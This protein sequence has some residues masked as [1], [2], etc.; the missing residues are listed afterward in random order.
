MNKGL[1]TGIVFATASLLVGCSAAKPMRIEVSSP[2]A[3]AFRAK[4]TFGQDTGTIATEAKSH[5]GASLEFPAQDGSVE[6]SKERPA[7]ELQVRVFEGAKTVV[8]V[9]S[10]AGEK[11]LRASRTRGHWSTEKLD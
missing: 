2:A 3:T 10:P 7:E 11:G 4:Y 6:V 5:G 1:I 8:D 9:K